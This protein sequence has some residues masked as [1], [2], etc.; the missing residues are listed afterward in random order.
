MVYLK[1]SMRLVLNRG[2]LCCCLGVRLRGPGCSVAVKMPSRSAFGCSGGSA[3]GSFSRRSN[4]SATSGC[5]G[6]LFA[7]P[8]C[9]VRGCFAAI[10]GQHATL[11][12]GGVIIAGK[13]RIFPQVIHSRQFGE[14]ARFKL[15]PRISAF[16][17]GGEFSAARQGRFVGSEANHQKTKSTDIF[18]I[19]VDF[20]I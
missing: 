15:G 9:R 13:G 11:G 10:A 14:N 12:K 2:S 5:Q 18:G 16:F 17:A 7:C 1:W 3:G 8:C 6:R 19:S 4:S 20:A